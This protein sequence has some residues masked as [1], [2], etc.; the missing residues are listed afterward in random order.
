MKKDWL[1]YEKGSNYS[2]IG[3]LL[4]RGVARGYT[5]QG[6]CTCA[7]RI[8][9]KVQGNLVFTEKLWFDQSPL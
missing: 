3:F 6:A 8:S 4:I 9:K 5:E 2:V 1:N 7:S